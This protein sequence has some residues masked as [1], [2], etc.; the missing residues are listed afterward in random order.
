MKLFNNIIKLFRLLN[1][2]DITEEDHG[3]VITIKGNA[4][5]LATGYIIIGEPKDNS[6]YLA[7]SPAEV[8]QEISSHVWEVKS[9]DSATH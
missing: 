5:L 3:L 7:T 8:A 9:C 4:S 2:L 1:Q 6:V